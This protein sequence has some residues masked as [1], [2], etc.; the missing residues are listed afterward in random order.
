MFNSY[1]QNLDKLRTSFDKSVHSFNYKLE[2]SHE[3]NKEI[4][5]N[6]AYLKQRVL[7]KEID[8]NFFIIYLVVISYIFT[9]R[10]Y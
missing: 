2:R 6:I 8:V 3:E 4:K 5:E 9:D 7:Y 1:E 10:Y